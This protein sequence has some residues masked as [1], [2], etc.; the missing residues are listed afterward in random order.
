MLDF[1]FIW[2]DEPGGNV[3]HIAQHDFTPEEVIHA[4][5]NVVRITVSRSSGLPAIIG[6]IPG[7]ERIFVAYVE[8]DALTVCVKTAYRI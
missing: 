5:H 2:D 7:G 3:E 6:R 8:I 1:D 4:F